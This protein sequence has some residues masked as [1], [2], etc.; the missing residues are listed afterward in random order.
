MVRCAYITHQ[1]AKTSEGG[2]E[3]QMRW[4]K[5]QVTCL[6]P[7]YEIIHFDPWTDSIDDFDLVHIFGPTNFP[8]ESARIAAYAKGHGKAVVTSSIFHPYQGGQGLSKAYASLANRLLTGLRG[9]FLTAPFDRL[10]PYIWL[11]RTLADS[12]LVL[13][14]S[15]LEMGSLMRHFGLPADRFR[16]VPNGVNARFATGDLSLFAERYGISDFILWVGR[17][18][19]IKNVV[20]LIESFERSKL[21]TEL[22]IIGR[23]ADDAYY[24][25]CKSIAGDRVRFLPPM[26]HDSDILASAYAASKVIALPSR[27]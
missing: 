1:L 9:M 14:N 26:P 23:P 6:R 27:Y 20:G 19:P 12:D 16:V 8:M 7:D 11:Y 15:R 4:T 10:N 5:R 22:V 21:D 2:A 18:E 13:P 17:I 25:R 24:E 3:A